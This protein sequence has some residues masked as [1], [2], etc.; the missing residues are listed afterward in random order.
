MP[1]GEKNKE[2]LINIAAST[3]VS[4]S[5]QLYYYFV[6]FLWLFNLYTVFRISFLSTLA[7]TGKPAILSKE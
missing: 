2:F 3:P 4:S 6:I 1:S 5:S 7:N